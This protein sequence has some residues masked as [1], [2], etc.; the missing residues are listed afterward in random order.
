MYLERKE[1]PT[2]KQVVGMM[3][4]IMMSV[5]SLGFSLSGNVDV[6]DVMSVQE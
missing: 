2:S 6:S 1:K 3:F 5:M 4:Q